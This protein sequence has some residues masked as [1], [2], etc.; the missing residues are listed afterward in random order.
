MENILEGHTR[1][2]CRE[3]V[4]DHV[5][6]SPNRYIYNTTSVPKVQ[7]IYQKRGQKKNLRARK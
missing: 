3:Q 6:L 2:K 1:S 4:R 5:V 7:G